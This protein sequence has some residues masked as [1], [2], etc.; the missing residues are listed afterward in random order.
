[1]FHGPRGDGG[2]GSFE[3]LPSD[4][5]AAVAALDE[6]GPAGLVAAVGVVVAGE[7]VAPFVEDDLLGVAKAD[8]EHFHAGAVGVAAEDGAGV[9]GAHGAALGA[10]DG[11]AVADAEVEAAVGPEGEAVEVMA[12]ESHADA[13]AVG[14]A[15]PGVGDA[16]EVVVAQVPD[17]GDVG[18][19]HVVAAGEDAGRDAVEGGCE[20]VGEHLGHVGAAVA[21]LVLEEAD[22]LG[23][24][25]VVL[26]PLLAEVAS[27]HHEAILDGLAGEVLVQPVHDAADVGH[28]APGAEAFD[29]EDA[30]IVGDVKGH[31]MGD[32]GLGGE[33]LA[34]PA[35]GD[36]EPFEEAFALVG[37]GGDLGGLE[38]ALGT[39]LV[40]CV[41]ARRRG[42]EDDRKTKEERS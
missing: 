10:E 39:Q 1:M 7:E 33:E 35:L 37:G 24:L 20:V 15:A 40:L 13:V 11:G 31:A 19:P 14:D 2:V 38:A 3:E 34:L 9:G 5:P 17:V 30:A 18:E 25:V 42:G 27:H 6:V 4:A 41:D 12:E 23:V 29:D 16:V 32:V 22:A 36:A 8:V 21:V 28:A 26:H